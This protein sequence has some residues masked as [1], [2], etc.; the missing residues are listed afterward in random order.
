MLKRNISYHISEDRLDRACYIMTTI[1]MGEIIKEVHGVDEQ[2]RGFWK[3]FTDTGVMLIF[4]ERK[5]R[6][7][8]LY[9]A[10]QPQVS[11]MYQG[12]TPSWILKMVKKNRVYAE[13]QNKVRV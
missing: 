10:S 7:V 6:V 5:E 4:N 11:A 2:G 9:I 3:C 1:G 12:N 13:M 8:T